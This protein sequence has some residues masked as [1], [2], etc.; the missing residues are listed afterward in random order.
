M[1]VTK[2]REQRE[3]DEAAKYK[4]I[5]HAVSQL[6]VWTNE[7]GRRFV[8]EDDLAAA[9]EVPGYERKVDDHG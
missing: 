6:K 8:F 9:L 4:R 1:T 2:E 3:R 7:D 5:Y